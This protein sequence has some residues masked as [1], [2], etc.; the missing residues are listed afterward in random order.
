[1]LAGAELPVR[2]TPL[3]MLYYRQEF[4]TDMV[5]DY[6]S[7][8]DALLDAVPELADCFLTGEPVD[9]DALDDEACQ[10]AE[11]EIYRT[12]RIVW[13][14]VKASDA[15]T[16]PF[17][18]WFKSID[19]A[20]LDLEWTVAA[21]MIAGDG[22]L[23]TRPRRSGGSTVDSDR[24]DLEWLA[25]GVHCG[26]RFDEMNLLRVQDL[27]DYADIYL[28]QSDDDTVRD[29]TQADIDAFFG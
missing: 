6:G 20:V 24:P 17:A 28:P 27:A 14:M 3:S 22:L 15:V 23:V 8:V 9:V 12:L 4:G 18:R 25:L 26:L 21:L 10:R 7:V 11:V 13:A 19:G 1:M 5:S 16:P 2:A 29:A